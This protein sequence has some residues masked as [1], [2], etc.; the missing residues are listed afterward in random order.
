M[1]IVAD[2]EQLALISDALDAYRK[3]KNVDPGSE[4]YERAAQRVICLFE[5]GMRDPQAMSQALAD[6]MEKCA[7]SGF[8]RPPRRV[9]AWNGPR[10]KQKP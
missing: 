8:Y 3:S 10:G 2:P 5:S 9:S 7:A 4:L 6:A 1:P